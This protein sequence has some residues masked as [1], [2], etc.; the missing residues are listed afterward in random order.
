MRELTK[1]EKVLLAV[2]GAVVLVIII[3]QLLPLVLQGFSGSEIANR[4][5]KLQTAQD[6]VRLAQLTEQ[7]EETL[8]AKVGLQ[9][10]IISD[11]LFEE[12]SQQGD[13][14]AFNQVRRAS[15]LA[16]LHPALAGKAATL[17]GYKKQHG[18][19]DNMD[20]LKE[21]QGPIFEGEQPQAVIS[22]RISQLTRKA[23]LK[24]DY[25]LNIKPSPGKKSAK[26]PAQAK[27]NL[28]LYLYVSQLDVEL[29]QLQEQQAEIAQTQAEAEEK[30]ESAMFDGW[31]GD[32][33]STESSDE[34]GEDNNMAVPPSDKVV[35]GELQP[36]SPRA[37]E[38]SGSKSESKTE[39]T[40]EN[41][42][43]NDVQMPQSDEV[44]DGE[45]QLS[46]A[47]TD[48]APAPEAEID[49]QQPSDT[50]EEENPDQLSPKEDSGTENRHFGQLPEIIPIS[51][52]VQLIEFIRSHIKL[53]V[54]GAAESKR[55]F[56]GDQIARVNDESPSGFGGFGSKKSVLQVGFRKDSVLFA[57]FEELINQYE[58]EQ[59]YDSGAST[60]DTLDY[61]RQIM[62]LTEYVD[63]IEQQIEQLQGWFAK[64]NSTYKPQ[65]YNVE[66]NFKGEVDAVVRLIQSIE[67]STKWLYVRNLKIANDKTAKEKTRLSVDL[68][69]I[70]KIL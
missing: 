41:S 62:A 16:T 70:A 54:G 64:V 25:Q 51:L 27:Q 14:K 46:S 52:R 23:G 1:R 15:D 26:V 45:T 10:R 35:K 21:I 18:E 9:G 67:T 60:E 50:S 37:D 24:P 65:I 13:I 53:Q 6:L 48:E 31:W 7:V 43:D 36:S 3:L 61:E 5:Q 69:M 58:E 44:V 55:G 28:N 56:I 8:R 11:S 34:N 38:A 66:M 4:R 68:S 59:T 57:K 32:D 30:L 63:R 47:A 42:E 40:D 12:I 2:V 17:I 29:K 33:G 19:L 49:A 39:P 22:Q 20:K